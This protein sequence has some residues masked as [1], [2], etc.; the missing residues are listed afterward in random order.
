[1]TLD[2]LFRRAVERHRDA[3]ALI[4]RPTAQLDARRGETADLRSWGVLGASPESSSAKFTICDCESL[5]FK[6][7]VL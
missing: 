5:P 7:N 4:D 1:M 3:I 6:P 2:D